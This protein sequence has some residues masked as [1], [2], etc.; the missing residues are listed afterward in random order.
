[1]STWLGAIVHNSARMQLR[2]K[3]RHVH[4]SLDEPIG[5]AD[6]HSISDRLADRR[7]SPEDEYRSTEL[8]R[9][10]AHFQS[11]RNRHVHARSSDS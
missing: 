2:R 8:G 11:R 1:M 7:P 9:R 5:E 3:L 4:L 6:E 10:L